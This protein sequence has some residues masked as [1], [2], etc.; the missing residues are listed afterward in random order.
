MPL[1]RLKTDF[2]QE[3]DPGQVRPRLA[4]A[5]QEP[6]DHLDWPSAFLQRM[7]MSRDFFFHICPLGME[8]ER[9]QLT[10]EP[11]LYIWCKSL[12]SRH[13][14][15]TTTCLCHTRNILTFGSRICFYS[16]EDSRPPVADIGFL[17]RR[18]C[19]SRHLE[20]DSLQS[21]LILKRPLP[22]TSG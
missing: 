2:C 14:P 20:L 18:N 7:T 17:W 3:S 4:K 9:D 19:T 11:L 8:N 12:R 10:K 21:A 1:L 22:T 13:R 16:Q 6:Q 5:D 15:L